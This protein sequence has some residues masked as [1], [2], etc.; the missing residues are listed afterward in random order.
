MATEFIAFGSQG[1]N[2]GSDTTLQLNDSTGIIYK[3][4]ANG[5]NKRLEILKNGAVQG[6][7]GAE[8]VNV[9]AASYTVTATDNGKFFTTTGASGA[10]TFTLPA[11]ANVWDGWSAEFVNV[12]DQNLVVT[13]PS[14]KFV[15][16]GNAAATTATF[17]TA[18]HKIGSRLK[19]V[20]DATLAKF[21][22][23]N[24]GG[25]AVTVS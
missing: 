5:A 25:T 10:V 3:I 4:K 7:I 16:D 20:F 8:N 11:I 12:V 19:V 17:S 1:N 23:L 13:A 24:G 21:I 22:G 14:G 18:S 2:P 15:L 9:Q 6:T